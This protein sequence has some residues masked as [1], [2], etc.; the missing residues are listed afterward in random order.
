MPVFVMCENGSYHKNKPF[1][2]LP[3][4]AFLFMQSCLNVIAH[5]EHLRIILISSQVGA[6]SDFLDGFFQVLNVLLNRL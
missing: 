1:C 2:F 5:R 6:A 3:V 4:A